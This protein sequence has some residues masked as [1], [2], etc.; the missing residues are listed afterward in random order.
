[1]ATAFA[2]AEATSLL[3][4]EATGLPAEG[5]AIDLVDGLAAAEEEAAAEEAIAIE[6][7]GRVAGV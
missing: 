5:L 7:A 4:A 2:V 1:L 6:A 3:V